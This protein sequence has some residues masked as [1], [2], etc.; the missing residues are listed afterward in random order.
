M[1]TYTI[2]SKGFTWMGIPG[3]TPDEAVAYVKM[4]E[5]FRDGEVVDLDNDLHVIVW[6]IEF[7]CGQNTGDSMADYGLHNM[8][9]T[10]QQ[11]CY[12]ALLKARA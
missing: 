4:A 10:E 3:N 6:N 11:R 8:T 12:A 7:R 5:Q 2:E 9:A 1:K